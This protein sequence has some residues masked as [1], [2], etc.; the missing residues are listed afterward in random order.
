MAIDMYSK[1]IRQDPGFVLA[2]LERSDI[3]S[4]IYFTKGLEY[5]YSGA[6]E[7]F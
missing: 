2:L 1:A 5:K 4:R 6:L 3:Y 7:R